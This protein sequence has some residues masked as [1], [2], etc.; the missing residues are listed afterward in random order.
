MIDA[1]AVREQTVQR[2]WLEMRKYV[3]WGERWVVLAEGRLQ[4]FEREVV[5]AEE[6]SLGI[7]RV[8]HC[9]IDDGVLIVEE[10]GGK[11]ILFRGDGIERWK[12]N[13]CALV[14]AKSK[15][16]GVRKLEKVGGERRSYL[17]H[18]FQH[19][20]VGGDET[21]QSISAL[22]TLST[23]SRITSLQLVSGSVWAVGGATDITEYYLEEDEI[24]RGQ[25]RGKREIVKRRGVNLEGVLGK[26]PT[27]NRLVS[28]VA[29]V[30]EERL[31]VAVGGRVV[32]VMVDSDSEVVI[33]RV[34]G[35]GS[36]ASGD[37][38]GCMEVVGKFGGGWEVWSG[39]TEGEGVKR[40]SLEGDFI[41]DLL[42]VSEDSGRKG[43]VLMN[44]LVIQQMKCDGC[45][46]ILTEE[47]LKE[48]GEKRKKIWRVIP[49]EEIQ[50]FSVDYVGQPREQHH[51]LPT[52]LAE[53]DTGQVWIGSFSSLMSCW[54]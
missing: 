52:A 45:V 29:R 36:G 53:T 30:G 2:G 35:K 8:I 19:P 40:W 42:L 20:G 22:F 38:V 18:Q 16:D 27:R 17:H 11:K 14:Q 37:A 5:G 47:E 24:D 28:C 4:W 3:G 51:D 48:T 6:G 43:G 49:Q 50:M 44:I 7:E 54:V 26:V 9:W 39:E 12:M 25:N 41:G 1:E 31:W 13:I 32:D 23:N 15:G 21:I 10:S 34:E 46:W 33:K